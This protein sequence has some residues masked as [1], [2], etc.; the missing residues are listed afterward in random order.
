MRTLLIF[1]GAV[2]MGSAQ[3]S[4]HL[5]YS[6]TNLAE[7]EPSFRRIL[8]DVH[9]RSTMKALKGCGALVA[10]M[11]KGEIRHGFF[12][13]ELS[14]P[15]GLSSIEKA[16]IHGILERIPANRRNQVQ[17]IDVILYDPQKRDVQGVVQDSRIEEYVGLR[18]L[19]AIEYGLF[20]PVHIYIVSEWGMYAQFSNE[21]S[22]H[23]VSGEVHVFE[24]IPLKE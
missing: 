13:S 18:N 19:L 12:S 5:H 20:I 16:L 1:L 17:R 14:A 2:A 24:A 23:E 4:E 15:N 21:P 22:H 3:A 9:H 10:R 6:L 11:A 8:R 7:L